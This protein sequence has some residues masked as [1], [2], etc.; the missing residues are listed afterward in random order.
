MLTFFDLAATGQNVFPGQPV[1][2]VINNKV[3]F[4]DRA[5]YDAFFLMECDKYDVT[6]YFCFFF[7]SCDVNMVVFVVSNRTGT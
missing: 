3:I 4:L 7:N 2:K 5:I 6:E 1:K